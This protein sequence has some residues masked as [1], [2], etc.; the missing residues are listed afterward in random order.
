MMTFFDMCERLKRHSRQDIDTIDKATDK[1]TER[2]V[3]RRRMRRRRRR[4]RRS[5][6]TMNTD[7]MMNEASYGAW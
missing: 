6:H 3:R 4:K 2:G 7:V 1:E 5:E